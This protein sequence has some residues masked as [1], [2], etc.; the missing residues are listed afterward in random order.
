MNP[1]I[2]LTESNLNK[3]LIASNIIQHD[4]IRNMEKKSRSIK[5]KVPLT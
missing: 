2:T 3:E 4:F 1:K 5:R